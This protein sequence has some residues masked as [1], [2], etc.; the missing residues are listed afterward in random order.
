MDKLEEDCRGL[1]C[2]LK[3]CYPNSFSKFIFIVSFVIMLRNIANKDAQ[4]KRRPSK[5]TSKE[6][7]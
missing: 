5:E 3:I 6:T 1:K 2:F 7:K 4:V